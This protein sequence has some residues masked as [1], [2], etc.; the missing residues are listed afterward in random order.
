MASASLLEG[1]PPDC[2]RG[3]L[4]FLFLDYL[5]SLSLSSSLMKRASTD[6]THLFTSANGALMSE[7]QLRSLLRRYGRL[8]VLKLHGPA[9]VGDELFGIL[10]QAS[11]ASNLKEIYLY[12][13]CLSYWCPTALDLDHLTHVTIAGGSIRAEFGSVIKSNSLQSL[14]IAQC[15]SLG[16]QHLFDMSQ[17]LKTTL[18][19]LYV[20]QCLQVRKPRIQCDAL[21]HLSLLGCFA[22]KDLP[23][24]RCPRL[25]SLCLS[26]CFRLEGSLIQNVVNQLDH[27]TDLTLVNCPHLT[28]LT[29]QSST[30][31]ACNV[32][33]SHRLRDLFLDCDALTYIDTVSCA[34]LETVT[35]VS[36]KLSTLNLS[37]LLS[38]VE[39][40][41]ST[42]ALIELR[43]CG[44]EKLVDSRVRIHG[45]SLRELDICGTQLSHGLPFWKHIPIIRRTRQYYDASLDGSHVGMG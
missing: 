9:P 26:F 10:N 21:R 23:D 1:L 13:C 31:K 41:L 38:L 39:L 18:E 32:S 44:C 20:K 30:L 36:S 16:D 34:T 19:T 45:P 5:L 29:I 12:D 4:S 37:M 6:A 14:S 42:P 35:V 40:D 27:L 24:F 15:A 43:L 2:T 3:V 33:L 28:A 11:C 22:L 25:V 7:R 17:R 8:N